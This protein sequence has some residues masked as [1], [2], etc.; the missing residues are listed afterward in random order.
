MKISVRDIVVGALFVATFL[1]CFAA[2]VYEC[3]KELP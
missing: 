1:E 3:V 2:W